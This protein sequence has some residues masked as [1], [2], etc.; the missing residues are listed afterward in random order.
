MMAARKGCRKE[1]KKTG[2]RV[3][4]RNVDCSDLK[5]D[6]PIRTGTV[7]GVIFGFRQCATYAKGQRFVRGNAANARYPGK[8]SV[9]RNQR[10][11]DVHCGGLQEKLPQHNM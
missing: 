10:R 9:C 8:A 2:L 6:D 7:L 4:L 11:K 1:W 5:F 3:P